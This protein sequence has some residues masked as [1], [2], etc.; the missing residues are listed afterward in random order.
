VAY[1]KKVRDF[2]KGKKTYLTAVTAILT[3]LVAWSSDS[4]SATE[5]VVALFVAF[6]TMFIRAGMN[7]ETE[8]IRDEIVKTADDIINDCAP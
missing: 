7:K 4:I 5:L 6:Q 1:S 8:K 2:L 3:A